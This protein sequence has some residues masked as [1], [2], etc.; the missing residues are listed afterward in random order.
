MTLMFIALAFSKPL[1]SLHQAKARN[2][3]ASP[4]SR[5]SAK[6]T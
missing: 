1:Y 6:A 5:H 4:S 3:L 2:D